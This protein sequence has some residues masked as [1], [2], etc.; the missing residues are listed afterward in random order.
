MSS[1]WGKN[2]KLEISG[3]SHEEFISAVLTGLPK[4]ISIS[5]EE[6]HEFLKRRS[7]GTSNAVSGRREED[8]PLILGGITGGKTDGSPL[9]IRIKNTNAESGVYERLKT[10]P[11]PGHADYTAYIKWSGREDMRGGGKFSGRMTAPICAAG[12]AAIK[13]LEE[14]GIEITAHISSV[15][16]IKDTPFNPLFISDGEKEAIKSNTIPVIS[17]AAGEEMLSYIS[18]VKNQGDSTG[19]TIECAITGLKPGIGDALFDGI[20]SSLSSIIFAIPGVKGIEFGSGFSGSENIGSVNN[21]PFIIKDGAVTCASNNA[22]G[23]LGGISTGLPVV[24]KA[25]FKPTPSIALEQKSVDLEAMEE[26]TLNI[27]GRHDPC[28]ALRAAPVIEACAALSIMDLLLEDNNPATIEKC[29]EKIDRIDS[30]ILPLLAERFRVTDKIGELK[31]AHNL[32]VFNSDREKAILENISAS[33]DKSCRA[34]IASIYMKI[35]QHSKA[36]QNTAGNKKEN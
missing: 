6:M 22:G 1:E 8:K 5:E 33:A 32:P 10:V 28:I 26:C 23:I 27:L 21:D 36:R 29:R 3:R 13:F 2:L 35:M 24:F 11:R 17:E 14:Q 12:F 30:R 31:A 9:K 20:E 25:A 4:G 34:D 19:G 16:T 18:N 7:P 15:G